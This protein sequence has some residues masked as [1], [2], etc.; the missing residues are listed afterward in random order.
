MLL[1]A[2]DIAALTLPGIQVI[3]TYY[4]QSLQVAPIIIGLVPAV[5]TKTIVQK[6]SQFKSSITKSI[7][8]KISCTTI[9]LVYVI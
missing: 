6:W 2:A 5:V 3:R 7:S 8:R 1:E 4:Q 9:P